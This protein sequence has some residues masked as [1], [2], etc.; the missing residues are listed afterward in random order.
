MAKRKKEKDFTD[1]EIAKLIDLFLSFDRPAEGVT[2]GFYRLIKSYFKPTLVGLENIPD[3]PTLFVGNHAMFAVDGL[4]LMPAIYDATGRFPRGMGDNILFQT[5]VGERLARQGL[6]LAH[7]EVCS[8]LMDA[9]Q[10]LMVFPGGAAE[11]NKSAAQKYTLQW[12]E[13]YGFVRMAA[14]H[15]YNITPFG[16]V[17]P[18]EWYDQLLEG[19]ELRKS[20]LFKLL[21][22]MGV[23]K[24]DFREDLIPPIPR[25]MFNTLLPK[26]QRCYLAFG[27]PVRVPDYSGRTR[28]PKALQ[29]QLR[30]ETAE[31][32]EALISRM[33]LLRAQNKTGESALRR[34][35][36]R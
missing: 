4:I 27:E 25:G 28:V 33:L 31:R 13:R 22:R 12:K 8:A 3:E 11:A 10:D 7:P 6:V 26:P 2:R 16:L 19:D 23:I 1:E 36:T 24:E 9:G 21:K 29:E 17:G 34:Y 35:L 30:D 14:T 5:G 20:G 18:D 32:V 15:G